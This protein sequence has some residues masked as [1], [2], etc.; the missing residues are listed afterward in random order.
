MGRIV[1]IACGFATSI[2]YVRFLGLSGYGEYAVVLAFVGTLGIFTNLGQQAT[3][4][5]FL[6]ESYGRRDKKTMEEITHYY[7]VACAVVF[8]FLIAL[9]IAAPIITDWIYGDQTI[10]QLARLVF[11]SSLFEFVFSYFSIAL[12]V[13]REIKTLTYME[14]SKTVLQVVGSLI[15]LWLG[16]GVFGILLSSVIASVSFMLLSM[17]MYPK[18]R[19]RYNF[20]SLRDILS[21]RGEGHFKKFGRDGLFIAIDKNAGNLY[22]NIFLFALSTVAPQPIVG[23]IRLA[24]KL[25]DLPTSLAL[26][27]VSRLS[28]S[29]IS[30]LAGIGG[31]TLRKNI[32][33]LIKSTVLMHTFIT[34]G[35][36]ILVP[37][38]L[39]YVYGESFQVAQFPFFVITLLNLSFGFQTPATPILRV[40][41]KI[42][43][44][45][46]FNVTAMILGLSA[47]F[48]LKDT[49]TPVRALYVALTIY[50][51]IQ[52]L[53]IFPVWKLIAKKS[54]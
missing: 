20:P 26:N 31:E 14:N 2:L 40:Y 16:Y 11:I 25:A 9:A 29:V 47:F 12:Q 6:A 46:L 34:V 18:F 21:V 38:F 3:L 53:I 8:F 48:L 50:Q 23:L 1:T 37:I 28:S 17:S 24:F 7:A 19:K 15:L 51:T 27:S 42:Y 30:T 41:S 32:I 10:G 43:I 5:T 33:R 13:V 22:P 44:A 49:I 4:T 39:P 45:T 35:G 36:I 52:T 54:S